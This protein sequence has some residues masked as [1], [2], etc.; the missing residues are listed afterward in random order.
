MTE[1]T[2]GKVADVVGVGVETIRFC[3]RPPRRCR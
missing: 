2:I 3:E 1:M